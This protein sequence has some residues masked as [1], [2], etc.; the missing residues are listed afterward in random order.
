MVKE[1]IKNLIPFPKNKENSWGKTKSKTQLLEEIKSWKRGDLIATPISENRGFLLSEEWLGVDYDGYSF[2]EFVDDRIVIE[3]R[4][5]GNNK[6]GKLLRFS[7]D[8]FCKRSSYFYN[9]SLE[10]RLLKEKN[11]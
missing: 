4:M 7:I 8:F 11:S 10:D 3:D 2:V 1:F 5:K 6:Q 9:Y